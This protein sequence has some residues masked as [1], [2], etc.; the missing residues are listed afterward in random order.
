MPGLS[1]AAQLAV[2]GTGSPA[3]RRSGSV[4]SGSTKVSATCR[5]S[6]VSSACQN[7]RCRRAAVEHQQPVAAAGDAG[8]GDQVDVV[9]GGAEWHRSRG[10]SKASGSRVGSPA[11]RWRTVADRRRRAVRRDVGLEVVGGRPRELRG[12]VLSTAGRPRGRRS[13][14]VLSPSRTGN[15]CRVPR[16]ADPRTYRGP[17]RGRIP[18]LRVRDGLAA[19]AGRRPTCRRCGYR[20]GRAAADAP[21]GRAAARASGTAAATASPRPRSAA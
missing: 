4:P 8:A 6:A 7:C 5:S 14:P 10:A 12:R 21:D 13:P 19:G 2:C 20:V 3:P 17:R 18:L 11:S 9:L 16:R 1:I 15:V